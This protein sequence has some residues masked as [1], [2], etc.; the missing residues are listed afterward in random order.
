MFVL[1]LR[2][3]ITH[4]AMFCAF[5]HALRTMKIPLRKNLC[6]P[7]SFPVNVTNYVF[8]HSGTK[9]FFIPCGQ[10]QWERETR[11]S[12]FSLSPSHTNRCCVHNL[13]HR[14]PSSFASTCIFRKP[15]SSHSF[16]GN[17]HPWPCHPNF[18]LTPAFF[19]YLL[20]SSQSH[21]HTLTEGKS[22]LLFHIVL[23]TYLLIVQFSTFTGRFSCGSRFWYVKYA[24]DN[25]LYLTSY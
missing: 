8:W 18:F 13:Q 21:V 17:F 2:N 11:S 25:I 6:Y 24:F 9:I 4:N 5:S 7:I 20:R 23:S 10:R 16:I 12:H 1:I 22:I 19:L 3:G 15:S 14:P